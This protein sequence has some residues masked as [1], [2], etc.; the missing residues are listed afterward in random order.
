MRIRR[1]DLDGFRRISARFRFAEERVTLWA[2]PNGRGKSSLAEALVAALYGADPHRPGAD[3]GGWI[4]IAVDLD[5][6]RSL[7]ISR[8]LS[9]GSVQVTDSGGR[10]V[11]AEFRDAELSVEVGERIFGVGRAAFEAMCVIRHADLPSTIG[12]TGL[13]AE[14]SRRA[15]GEAPVEE[16]A[17]AA[18]PENASDPLP[19]EADSGRTAPAATDDD[20]RILRSA[21]EQMHYLVSGEMPAWPAEEGTPA[22]RADA[23]DVA[24]LH[25]PDEPGISAVER[26]RRLRRHLE[27]LDGEQ[28]ACMA[29]LHQISDRAGE[30]EHEVR[31]LSFLSEA[32]PE[33]VDHLRELIAHI[34][35]AEEARREHAGAEAAFQR[36]LE[37][38]GVGAAQL[39]ELA[40]TFRDLSPTD[41]DFVARYRAEET[42]RRGNQALTRSESRLDES[43][44]REIGVAQDRAARTAVVPLAV[45]IGGLL[46][47]V[48]AAILRLP[49]LPAGLLLA[50]AVLAA[51][52]GGVLL[53]RARHV[54]ATERVHIAQSQ[55]RKKEQMSEL[56]REAHE[57]AFRLHDVGTRCGI[58]EANALLDRYEEWTARAEDLAVLDRFAREGDELDH[59]AAALREDLGR[60]AAARSRG[61]GTDPVLVDP[62]AVHAEY[63]RSIELRD[64]LAQCER[65]SAEKEQ[66][67]IE[68]ESGRAAIRGT[69]ESLLSDVGVNPQRDVDQALEA[70]G[71]PDPAAEAEAEA[72]A[73]AWT[74]ALSARA[75]AILRRL[76]P[77][78]R[79]VEVNHR[80]VLKLRLEPGGP[81]MDPQ[82]LAASRSESALEQVCLALRLAIVETLG[83]AG[84]T[85]P[86]ILDDPL[87]RAD[88]ARHD[89][90]LEFLV[91]DASTRVQAVL[92][93]AHEVRA[94]WFLHQ[95]P[96]AKERVVALVDS[97][98]TGK[99]PASSGAVPS[100]A[101]S[102]SQPAS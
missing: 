21:A 29:E 77:E 30:I 44:I 27:V 45:S 48:A 5:D 24:P 51:T 25:D 42:V 3:R 71:E 100:P 97:R 57:S 15:A 37:G 81:L 92:M 79:D 98:V 99:R 55:A 69:I 39:R 66:R 75:E 56:E 31:R 19:V 20:F 49:S 61:E 18:S 10:D 22:G 52:V 1:V 78:A 12:H 28:A 68:L 40:A 102:V 2:A 64:S 70:V 41:L 86:L 85:V 4:Q 87:V 76:L 89:R 38:R 9:S 32:T 95:H 65:D 72:R 59:A 84:E 62:E 94:K 54:G 7:T 17:E 90:F 33:D 11:T 23:T 50:V 88:D 96:G 35:V 73:S 83:S 74:P 60:F 13:L 34:E 67:L 6:G 58:D 63:A 26:M 46:A 53:W 101:A 43:R 47:A 93:T 16:P 36:E 82:E 80:L 8:N 91:E 14:L